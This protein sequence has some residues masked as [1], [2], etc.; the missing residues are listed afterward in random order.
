MIR[1]QHVLQEIHAY[2]YC[3]ENPQ[4]ALII[5][6]GI[7]SHG[8]IYDVFCEHHAAKGADIWAFDAPGHGKSTTNRPRGQWTLEE[9]IEASKDYAKHVKSLTGLPVFAL[10]SSLGVAAAYGSLHSDDVQGAILMGSPL[11]PSGPF[12]SV[13]GP[14][15]RS[16]EVQQVIKQLGRAGRLDC[17]ILFNFDEDYGYAGAGEQK[18]LD[19]W[20]TWSYDLESWS[21]MFTHE[22]ANPVGENTKPILMACGE[23]DPTF[24]PELMQKV[25]ESIAG[26]VKFSCLAGASHQLMLFHTNEF[27]TEVHDWVLEQI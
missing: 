11:V 2:R 18:R 15:W 14:A 20:N 23:K 6:H 13:P 21:T 1:E 19:P 17:G 9:W 8:G 26:P 25:A 22:V 27:S 12:L 16:P 7:A 4:Y 3:G 24:P 10:G 5:S